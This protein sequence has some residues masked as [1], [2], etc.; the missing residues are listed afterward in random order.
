MDFAETLILPS[1]LK[2]GWWAALVSQEGLGHHPLGNFFEKLFL[3]IAFLC[4]LGFDF[5][6]EAGKGQFKLA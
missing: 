6:G 2:L 4:E 1:M 5:D 3:L